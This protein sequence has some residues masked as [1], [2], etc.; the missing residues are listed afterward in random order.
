MSVSH[1]LDLFDKLI[2]PILSYGSE[3]WGMNEAVNLE[4]VHMQF[5]KQLLGVRGQ[6]QNIFIYGELGRYPLKITR[7]SRVIKYWFKVISCPNEKYVKCVYTMMLNDLES[8]PEKKSWARSVKTL[9]ES[10]G[11]N[12]VWLNQGVVNVEVFLSFFKQRLKDHYCQGWN[13]ELENSSRARMY[14]LFGN[15]VYQPY[16]DLIQVEK[17]RVAL[18]RFRV[19]AHRLAVESGRWHKPDK[20]PYNERKCQLCNCLE[21]EF[22]F[23]LECPLNSEIRKLYIKGYYWKHP[24][25]VK[26]I[27]LLK[28]ENEKT[29]RMLAI[30]IYKGFEKRNSVYYLN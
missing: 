30:F 20:I 4:R 21:D 19:S 11:F 23:L 13:N 5:C 16:L 3:V 27:E 2:E 8:Y 1:Q 9:L 17:F 15:F 12:H 10:L 29:Q 26:F 18:T 22:H 6:T 28:S 24:N 14:R 7:L 25:M